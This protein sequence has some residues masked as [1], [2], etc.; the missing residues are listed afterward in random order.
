MTTSEDSET[1]DGIYVFCDIEIYKP[2]TL[3]IATCCAH[4]IL[5]IPLV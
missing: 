4:E 1:F 5:L 3:P 2:D